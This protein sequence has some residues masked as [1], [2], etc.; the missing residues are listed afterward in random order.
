MTCQVGGKGEKVGKQEREGKKKKI[1]LALWGKTH[2]KKKREN[3]NGSCPV[4]EG[5]EEKKDISTR[6]D[7]AVRKK[8]K[9]KKWRIQ[10]PVVDQGKRGV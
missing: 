2:S 6:L 5:G 3:P 4:G 1:F 7:K 8:G 9:E 10:N